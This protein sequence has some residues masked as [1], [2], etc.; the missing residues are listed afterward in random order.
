MLA[1]R[2]RR[3][4]LWVT[5]EPFRHVVV[6]KLLFQIMP[7]NVWR[8]TSLASGSTMPLLQL[9]VELVG[10]AA[11]RIK[12]GVEIREG[13]KQ[14]FRPFV[15]GQSQPYVRRGSGFNVYFMKRADFRA[16]LFG[17]DRIVPA[18]H[19]IFVKGVLEIAAHL[20]HPEQP[21]R[22]G[23]VVAEQQGRRGIEVNAV[24]PH[25]GVQDFDSARPAD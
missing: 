25:I 13:P 2:R 7:A 14:G 6:V 11:A 21:A 4:L 20:F 24:L 3:R 12:N 9:G 17:I 16:D 18:L 23:V 15:P 5:I 22:I 1:L 10:L 8:C 19:E